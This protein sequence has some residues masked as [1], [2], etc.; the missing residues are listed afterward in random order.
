MARKHVKWHQNLTLRD[1]PGPLALVGDVAGTLVR[2]ALR[3]VSRACS[4]MSGRCRYGEN[5][6]QSLLS[7][8]SPFRDQRVPRSKGVTR[9]PS[10][11]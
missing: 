2:I 4:V 6:R 1:E 8:S 10:E 5:G 3:L 9:S 11:G 7:T